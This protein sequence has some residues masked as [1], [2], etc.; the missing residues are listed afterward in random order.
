MIN[1]PFFI[2]LIILFGVFSLYFFIENKKKI[3]QINHLNDEKSKLNDNLLKLTEQEA[4]LRGKKEQ[5]EKNFEQMQTQLE[6]KFKNL[7]TDILEQNSQKFTKQNIETIDK[8]LSPLNQNINDFKK[9]VETINSDETKRIS[10]LSQQIKDFN[11]LNQQISTEANNL[12]K[13][14]KG[15]SKTQGNWGEMILEKLL[16]YSGL[17][18]DIHYRIQPTINTKRPDVIINFPDNKY[19]VVDSKVSLV[20]YEKWVNSENQD[21]KELCFKE[22]KQS[23]KRHID[24]LF[25]KHYHTELNSPDFVF[26]FIPIEPAFHLITSS[27]ERFYSYAMEKNV[28]LVSPTTLLASLRTI[29]YIWKQ[30]NQN[31]NAITIAKQAGQ[32]Y[33][34]FVGFLEDMKKIKNNI[35]LVDENYDKALNKLSTGRGSLVSRAEK[36][37]KLGANATK[38]I[39]TDLIE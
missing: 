6:E 21:I 2:S 3:K 24:S 28:N 25:E 22:L 5:E 27:G 18:K 7:A 37:K 9:R 16:E 8:I 1:Y 23:L 32:L 36:I 13:A 14:L 31:K 20:A 11:D 39:D 26:M 17:K 35:R 4:N 15:E 38:Q 33:D 12:T 30:E 10:Y 29:S 19:V 34:K